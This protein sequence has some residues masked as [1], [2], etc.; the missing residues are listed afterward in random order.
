MVIIIYQSIKA[1]SLKGISII[2]CLIEIAEILLVY[3]LSERIDF[4]A[5]LLIVDDEPAILENLRFV[6]ELENFEVL[7]A[8][9][10]VEA[11]EIFE[12]NIDDID[13]VITDMRMPEKTGLELLED[14]K[15]IS[16][17][18]AVIILTGHGDMDNA[19]IAMK[20]GAYDYLNKPVNVDKLL[21]TLG[22]AIKRKNLLLENKKLQED[23]ITK[24]TYLQGLHDSAQKILINMLPE[25]LY[26]SDFFDCDAVY[27]SCDTVGGD[28]YDVFDMG[29]YICFYIFDVCSHGILSAV[30]A[31]IMKTYFDNLKFIYSSPNTQHDIK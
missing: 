8:A 3:P 23:L 24:N 9:C 17:E 2:S 14:I 28:M 27:K 5:K 15:K 30:I 4:M 6:L 18:M 1:L 29:D 21:I 11:L 19:I 26:K 12:N 10:G 7:S 31:L 25:S 16:E 20:N 22:N 13:A